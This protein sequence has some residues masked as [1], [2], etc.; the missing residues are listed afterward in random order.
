MM[1]L[2]RH[3]LMKHN[4]NPRHILSFHCSEKMTRAI[5]QT[6]MCII[7]F[8]HMADIFNS[9]FCAPVPNYI[10]KIICIKTAYKIHILKPDFMSFH[11]ISKKKEQQQ[12]QQFFFRNTQFY[13]QFS[14]QSCLP[15][16]RH[17]TSSDRRIRTLYV[18]QAGFIRKKAFD[19][20][21][22]LLFQPFIMRHING[23]DQH[24]GSL[25]L[26]RI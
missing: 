22:K 14:L 13:R 18:T 15:G 2:A 8:N 16:Q 9:P 25:F 19:H 24:L 21:S 7:I 12:F 26:Q 23:V 6:C 20:R 1:I 11:G 4:I 5:S 3:Q 10:R 17:L